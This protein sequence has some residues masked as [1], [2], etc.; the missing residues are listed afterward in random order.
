MVS[1]NMWQGCIL[2]LETHSVWLASSASSSPSNSCSTPFTCQNK[3]EALKFV[4][5]GNAHISIEYEQVTLLGKLLI[6]IAVVTDF[7]NNTQ[8]SSYQIECL[9][10]EHT[11]TRRCFKKQETK[12]WVL[13]LAHN[14]WACSLCQISMWQMNS[15]SRCRHLAFLASR[16]LILWKDRITV[17]QCNQISWNSSIHKH[18][19]G[20]EGLTYQILGIQ[21]HHHHPEQLAECESPAI[22]LS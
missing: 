7:L 16:P 9:L 19:M 3:F 14:A 2:T 18:E 22:L 4:R 6:S 8:H 12:Q 5:P 10:T 15:D 21:C 17:R 1:L 11:N 13:P 20:R